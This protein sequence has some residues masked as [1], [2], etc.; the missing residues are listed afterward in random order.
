[1]S[2]PPSKSAVV[3][4]DVGVAQ[5]DLG[6][7][8]GGDRHLVAGRVEGVVDDAPVPLQGDVPRSGGLVK[9]L[10]TREETGIAQACKSY[11]NSCP[12]KTNFK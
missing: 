12:L 11:K 5:L 1:M 9:L 6:D 2:L 10:D 7:G 8:D 4:D 3:S